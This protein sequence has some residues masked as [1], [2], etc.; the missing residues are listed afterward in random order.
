MKSDSLVS[1]TVDF[2]NL[3]K[4]FGRKSSIYDGFGRFFKKIASLIS[5][6]SLYISQKIPCLFPIFNYY[7]VTYQHNLIIILTKNWVK[8]VWDAE[9]EHCQT[10]KMDLFAKIVKVGLFQKVWF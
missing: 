2:W 7:I 9:S 5:V 1:A 8:I 6:F 4:L 3:V 10:S